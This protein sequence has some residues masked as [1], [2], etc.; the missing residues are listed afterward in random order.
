MTYLGI[1]LDFD[2]KI[3]SIPDKR[4]FSIST[5]IT[6][7]IQSLPYTT[8]RTLAKL[9]GKILSTKFVLGTIVQLKT[10]RLYKIIDFRTAWDSRI[11]MSQFPE[12]VSE[13][14]FWKNSF[15]ILNLRKLMSHK[16]VQTIEVLDASST[17]Y[18]ANLTINN[19][20]Y[21][22]Y[23]NLSEEESQKSSTWREISAIEF[24]LKAFVQLLKNSSV[25][26]KADNYASTFIVNS[27]SSNDD[28][29]K[30]AENIF[31]FCKES[32]ITLKVMWIPRA[33]LSSVD[34]LS[35]IIDHDDWRITQPCFEVLNK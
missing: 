10:R 21:T 5:T 2:N 7:I 35:K 9:C 20:Q 13:I 24:T 33:E 18:A 23:K 3:F 1:N 15:K 8:A 19:V 28:L 17:G 16:N 29:Q 30:T 31:Y 34:R 22:A 25:L 4:I 27:G 6:K 12:G 32:S 26:C 14:S 11:N